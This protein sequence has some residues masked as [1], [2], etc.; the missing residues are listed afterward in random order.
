MNVMFACICIC[1]FIPA[2]LT[3]FLQL[4]FYVLIPHFRQRVVSVLQQ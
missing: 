2:E 3:I 4:L 1:I